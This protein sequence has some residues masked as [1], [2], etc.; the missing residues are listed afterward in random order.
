[1]LRPW[2]ER[3]RKTESVR[4]RDGFTNRCTRCKRVPATI[5]WCLWDGPDESFDP[6]KV[7]GA[8]IASDLRTA[9]HAQ[10]IVSED[11]TCHLKSFNY[12]L[13]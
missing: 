5:L 8:G 13:P 12:C 11:L 4:A 1:M 6:H 9:L 7:I 10:K 3:V 2:P